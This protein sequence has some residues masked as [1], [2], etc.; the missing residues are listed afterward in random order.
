MRTKEQIDNLVKAV[1][2]NLIS[3]SVC[4]SFYRCEGWEKNLKYIEHVA[5]L[6]KY[7]PFCGKK[8]TWDVG[9]LPAICDRCQNVFVFEKGVALSHGDRQAAFFCPACY[10]R[11]EEETMEGDND[12][13]TTC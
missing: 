6:F 8:I 13:K 3:G 9:G 4:D 2:D 10:E 11:F 12:R 5:G 7:C 1:R